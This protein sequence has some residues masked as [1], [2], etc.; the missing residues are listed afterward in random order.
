VRLRRRPT[1]ETCLENSELYLNAGEGA[2]R[3][4]RLRI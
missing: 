2:V 4:E 1:P 3:Q